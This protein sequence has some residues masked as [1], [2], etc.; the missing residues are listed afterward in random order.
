MP[1][2]ALLRPFQVL[3]RSRVTRLRRGLRR[4]PEDPDICL[5]GRGR[6]GQYRATPCPA[7]GRDV[8]NAGQ[9]LVGSHGGRRHAGVDGFP[10]SGFLDLNETAPRWENTSYPASLRRPCFALSSRQQSLAQTAPL[11]RATNL[12]IRVNRVP[13]RGF[14][15]E[16]VPERPQRLVVK[17]S[18]ACAG[19][20]GTGFF[21]SV[22]HARPVPVKGGL[23]QAGSGIGLL[24]RPASAT[25][26]VVARKEFKVYFFLPHARSVPVKR[27]SCTSW[28]GQWSGDPRRTKSH[29][30]I[31]GSPKRSF[32]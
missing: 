21:L 30:A 4:R 5:E 20:S 10:N 8:C 24:T 6:T 2:A 19:P 27:W 23:V 16:P 13:P 9:N 17:P 28:F 26:G 15:Q 31:A 22:P 1:R 29:P 14:V 12:R 18:S 11:A 25:A 32:S 7:S 3:S